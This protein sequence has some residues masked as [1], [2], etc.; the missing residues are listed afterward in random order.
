[1]QAAWRAKLKK[2][3]ERSDLARYVGKRMPD[4]F[5]GKRPE[6]FDGRLARYFA[7]ERRPSGG[8]E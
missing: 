5:D 4:T 7:L 6:D 3:E 1:M 8:Q 2:F